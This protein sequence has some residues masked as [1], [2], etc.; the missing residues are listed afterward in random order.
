[1]RKGIVLWQEAQ[2]WQEKGKR[3]SSPAKSRDFGDSTASGSEDG[4]MAGKV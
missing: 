2:A 4:D 3:G 1:M